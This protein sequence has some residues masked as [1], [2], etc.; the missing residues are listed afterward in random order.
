[1][2][3]VRLCTGWCAT[4]LQAGVLA[5]DHAR[6]PIC[7]GFGHS[8]LPCHRVCVCLGVCT[9]MYHMLS[10]PQE[11]EAR[12][13]HGVAGGWIKDGLEELAGPLWHITTPQCLWGRLHWIC[14]Q[15]PDAEC[16]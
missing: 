8:L 5:L 1:M 16:Y 6:Q 9:R 4:W 3:H 15:P 10:W 2:R 14:R 13:G 7:L 12:P 11:V